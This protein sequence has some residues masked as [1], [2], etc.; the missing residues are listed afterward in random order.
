M[1]VNPHR[2]VAEFDNERDAYIIDQLE[3]DPEL[4]PLIVRRP[5]EFDLLHTRT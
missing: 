5:S 2:F 4:L 1:R 3:R